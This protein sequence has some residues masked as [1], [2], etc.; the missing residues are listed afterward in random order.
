MDNKCIICGNLA[1]TGNHVKCDHCERWTH[2]QCIGDDDGQ[3]QDETI[4]YFFIIC[5]ANT[6]S[7]SLQDIAE[8]DS[9][10]NSQ[11][12]HHDSQKENQEN[13]KNDQQG[14]RL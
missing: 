11:E 10:Q 4:H 9:Q 12:W 2:T 7:Q 1:T 8:E 6:S 14:N 5:L 13:A 3:M